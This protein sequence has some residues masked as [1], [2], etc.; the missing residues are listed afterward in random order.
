MSR[1]AFAAFVFFITAA[2][3]RRVNYSPFAGRT[4]DSPER[5][6]E[7]RIPGAY[8]IFMV[9]LVVIPKMVISVAL[10]FFGGKLVLRSDDSAEV[11]MNSL[12]AYFVAGTLHGLRC[13]PP[14][15]RTVASAIDPSQPHSTLPQKWTSTCIPTCAQAPFRRYERDVS[16]E[17][18]FRYFHSCSCPPLPVAGSARRRYVPAT[19]QEGMDKSDA[20]LPCTTYPNPCSCLAAKTFLFATARPLK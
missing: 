16:H 20:Y 9:F 4:G 6:I 11:I 8:R 15:L 2:N 10:L 3:H 19:E 13:V 7:S 5:E 12:A 1:S 18:L 14:E 17:V